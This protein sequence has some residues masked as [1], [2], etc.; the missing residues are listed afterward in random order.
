MIFNF[1][2]SEKL[3]RQAQKR[4]SRWDTPSPSVSAVLTIGE[5][6]TPPPS[7]EV[8]TVPLTGFGKKKKSKRGKGK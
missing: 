6:S 8:S 1:L 2:F 5:K 3:K 7:T 4:K